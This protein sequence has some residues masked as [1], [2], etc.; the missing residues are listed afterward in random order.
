MDDGYI[1]PIYET[2][3][4]IKRHKTFVRYLKLTMKY[5]FSHVGLCILLSIYCVLGCAIFM[6]ID[7]ANEQQVL[8]DGREVRKL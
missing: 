4:K 8:A 5:M 2:E 3:K 1:D 6:G 7:G